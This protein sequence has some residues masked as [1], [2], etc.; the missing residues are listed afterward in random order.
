MLI[1]FPPNYFS[2][3]KDFPFPK[4]QKKFWREKNQLSKKFFNLAKKVGPIYI[5]ID[6]TKTPIKK[7]ICM[8]M[9]TQ[10][11]RFIINIYSHIGNF[12]DC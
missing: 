5:N 6:G 2:A 10:I 7:Y 9:F 4:Y 3:Q 11:V 12:F 8:C 1:F